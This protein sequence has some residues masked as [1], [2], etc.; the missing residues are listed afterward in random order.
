MTGLQPRVP[1]PHGILGKLPKETRLEIYENLFSN[2]Y[3]FSVPKTVKHSTQM[4]DVNVLITSSVI[5][6]EGR[7]LFYE[8][9]LFVVRLLSPESY[10]Y[11]CGGV[12][13][14]SLVRKVRLDVKI[15]HF[16]LGTNVAGEAKQSRK[17]Y[18]KSLAGAHGLD[19]YWLIPQWFSQMS[20]STC[21]ISFAEPLEWIPTKARQSYICSVLSLC[22]TCINCDT[23]ALVVNFKAPHSSEMSSSLVTLAECPIDRFSKDMERFL[24]PGM[25]EEYPKSQTAHCRLFKQRCNIIH[26]NTWIAFPA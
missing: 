5:L 11:I 12:A 21:F 17:R 24:R 10:C 1:T 20:L 25:V 16:G 9:G 15:D 19:L 3:T 18:G 4:A 23:V 13:S 26:A 14:V 6:T 7:Q 2:K 8:Q 22:N